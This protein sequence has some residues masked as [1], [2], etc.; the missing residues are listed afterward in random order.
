MLVFEGEGWWQRATSLENKCL[1]LF[2]REEGGG[3]GKEQLPS[4]T[5]MYACFRERRVVRATIG[6]EAEASRK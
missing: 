5:S 1:C 4:K 2:S 3:G 6:S